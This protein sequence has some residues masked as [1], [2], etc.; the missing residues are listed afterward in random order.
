MVAGRRSG[1][2]DRH[3][4]ELRCI[5]DVRVESQALIPKLKLVPC[6]KWSKAKRP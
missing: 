6:S 2:R 5:L 3:D 1:H 4:L